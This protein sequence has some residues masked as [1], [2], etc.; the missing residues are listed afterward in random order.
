MKRYHAQSTNPAM[1]EPFCRTYRA[2]ETSYRANMPFVL[3][4]QIG[5]FLETYHESAKC[6][7][8]LLGMKMSYKGP[9]NVPAAGFPLCSAEKHIATLCSHGY[10]VIQ[11]IQTE[12]AETKKQRLN[13]GDQHQKIQRT[14]LPGITMNFITDR[15]LCIIQGDAI[16]FFFSETNQYS[17]F[18]VPSNDSV[19]CK[20][21]EY[22]PCEIICSSTISFIPSI[23]HILPQI[24]VRQYFEMG[25]TINHTL[26]KFLSILSRKDTQL[27]EKN[28][29]PIP[30]CNLDARTVINLTLFGTQH[31]LLTAMGSKMTKEAH[32][33]LI[34][35]LHNPISDQ[36]AILQ[37]QKRIQ[38]IMEND[39]LDILYNAKPKKNS[40][41]TYRHPLHKDPMKFVVTE[42]NVRKHLQ[43]IEKTIL[44]MNL[45]SIWISKLRANIPYLEIDVPLDINWKPSEFIFT[46]IQSFDD[47]V[48]EIGVAF[49]NTY[50]V[51]VKIGTSAMFKNF[52]ETSVSNESQVRNIEEA[53]MVSKTKQVIRFDTPTLQKARLNSADHSAKL[54]TILAKEISNWMNQFQKWIKPVQFEKYAQIERDIC[55][56]YYFKHLENNTCFPTFDSTLP[57]GHAE[58]T[59]LSLPIE[60]TGKSHQTWIPTAT[61]GRYILYGSN[62]SGKTTHMR[63]IAIN[64][65]LAHCGLPVLATIFR[66]KEPVDSIRMR[67]GS[68]DCLAEGKSSFLVELEHMKMIADTMTEKSAIFIDEL[69]CSC[70]CASGAKIC[71][72]FL[73]QLDKTNCFFVFATHYDLSSVQIQTNGLPSFMEMGIE[74]G[75]YTF[76]CQAHGQN[77]TNK[78]VV[79]VAEKCGIP[80]N[81]LY[82]TERILMN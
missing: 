24:I 28:Q 46:P 67:F 82:M 32:L 56:A 17:I 1:Y 20:L 43:I 53:T 34:N 19:L 63:S 54:F 48:R 29:I 66:L 81:V 59:N 45:W 77:T 18:Q 52:F 12:N 13:N 68:N 65:L 22:R 14:T 30:K 10:S 15:P 79:C 51:D 5:K 8:E 69:G 25:F 50:L 57:Q 71:K 41:A 44:E 39:F 36:N 75:A 6:V 27:V 55:L 78:N 47:Q 31:S 70:D 2:F 4:I 9:N 37:Q 60:M 49:A 40:L 7:H 21:M 74:D 76:Y 35:M 73:E 26:E 11:T 61:Y 62:G 16:L 72:F 80:A 23:K 38:V 58:L 33:S 3:F 64:M 42:A